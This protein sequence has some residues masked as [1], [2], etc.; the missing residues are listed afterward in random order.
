MHR[1]GLA[2]CVTALAL[3]VTAPARGQR[4]TGPWDDATT[5]PRGTMRVTLSP[6]FANWRERY[7]RLDGMRE[8]LGTDFS[9]DSLGPRHVPFLSAAGPQLTTLTGLAS[10]PLSLGS[11]ATS[12]EVTE[13]TTT[14]TL[15][16]GL[17]R[18][19][20]LGVVVPYVKNHVYVAAN[21]GAGATLGFN[22]ARQFPG[23]RTQNQAV[24]TM[25]GTAATTLTGELARC[26]GLTEPSCAAINSDRTG[27]QGLVQQAGLVSAA[28]VALYGTPTVAGGLYAPVAG[29]PLDLAVAA[30]LADLNSRFRSFLGAPASG[31]WISGRPAAAPPLAG[32]DI[33]A[34]LGDPA[35]GIAGRPFTDIEHSHVGDVE[36]GAKFRIV[37]TFGEQGTAPPPRAGA[38]RIAVAG[39]YRLPTGQLDHP[40]HFADLGAGQKQADIELRGFVDLSL[41]SAFWTS[42]VL[43]YSLQRPDRLVR[44]ITDLPGDPFPELAR[45]QEVGRDLG[46]VVEAEFAPRFVPNDEFSFSAIYRY[47]SR[48]KDAYSGTFTVAGADGSQLSLDAAT[49]GADSETREHLAGFAV[50]FST[51]RGAAR[52][53][54]RWPLEVSYIHTLI[55]AGRGVPRSQSNAVMLRVWR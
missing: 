11:L 10:P 24:A 49:L 33:A 31:E 13:V 6:S 45:E 3:S 29:G 26:T 9:P 36:V 37:D 14:I 5:A 32:A 48:G 53:L 1:A 23:A 18:R 17:T 55:M 51:V 4:V 42:V 15:D 40:D 54:A 28:L 52:R 7:S 20:G 50:T 43:R 41:G 16:Y 12:L 21:P 35:F 34:L 2:A 27:A 39:I 30:R 8:P 19:L 47:R 22:P 44:R 38:I 46:D 25:L